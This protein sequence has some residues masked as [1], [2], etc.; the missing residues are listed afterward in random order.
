MRFHTVTR[1]D[2]PLLYR[3]NRQ[4]AES[5]GQG[6]LFVAEC[7]EYTRAFAGGRPPVRAWLVLEGEEP[8][9]FILW[10][11]KFASYLGKMTLYVEDLWLG[12]QTDEIPLVEAVL[13][14][15]L[16]RADAMGY[17]RVEI[18]RLE[19]NG[20]DADVLQSRGFESV[21]KWKVWRRG[22]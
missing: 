2:L 7:G 13:D 3:L 19:W 15:L 21:E 17:P 20:I 1:D 14:E 11:E 12:E 4:M 5:E 22:K 10:Q 6:E 16:A 8:L 18:R 9:G